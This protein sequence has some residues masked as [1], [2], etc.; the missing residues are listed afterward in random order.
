MQAYR[1][2]THAKKL[3]QSE[4]L[5]TKRV[6]EDIPRPGELFFEAGIALAVPLFLALVVELYFAAWPLQGH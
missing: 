5:A 6:G 3:K 2:G 4:R 1:T